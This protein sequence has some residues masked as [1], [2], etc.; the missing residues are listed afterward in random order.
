[1]ENYGVELNLIPAGDATC[2]L[3]ACGINRSRERKGRGLPFNP[4]EEESCQTAALNSG[5][6]Q[7]VSFR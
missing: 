1:M 7:E 4:L 2:C 6:A 3:K 5:D